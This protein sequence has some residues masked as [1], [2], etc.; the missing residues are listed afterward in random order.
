[1]TPWTAARQAPLSMGLS[2][3]EHWSGWPCPPP[4]DLPHPGMQ[5]ESPAL[6]GTFF[7]T[8][9]LGSHIS[10]LLCSVAQSCLTLCDPVD[11]STPDLSA[12]HHLLKFAHVHVDYIREAI[13]V[14][15]SRIAGSYGNFKY[16]GHMFN[17]FLIFLA[18]PHSTQDLSS[19][20]RDR[21]HASYSE[22]AES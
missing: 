2:R 14:Y 4:G 18:K 12:P 15:I 17:L 5:P 3:Q 7:T 13:Y 19:L 11:C 21:T 22:S 20:T 6:A 16:R 8:V 1:M 10:L 9:P